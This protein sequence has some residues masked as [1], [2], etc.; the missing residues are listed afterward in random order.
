MLRSGA[1]VV[2]AGRRAE[3]IQAA[4]EQLK[5]HGDEVSG[6]PIDAG[7]PDDLRKLLSEMREIPDILVNAAGGN[8]PGATALPGEKNFFELKTEELRDV[9]DLNLFSGALLPCQ[10]IGEEMAR[11]GRPASIINITSVAAFLPLTRVV[12]YS[13][14][15]AAVENF[16]RWLAVHL[17]RDLHSQIRVNTLVPGFYLTEQNRYLL[18]REDGSLS[19]RGETIKAQT[20]LGRFGRPE[21]LAGAAIY[22]ASPASRY[23]TGS[24][25]AV[26][27][28]FTA[29]SGV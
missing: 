19:E 29:F 11:S 6:F 13:A 5:P 22:L 8:R 4:L 16:T 20:P 15:K 1:R 28:G 21:E 14:A 9:V 17:A 3:R 23:V 7:N 25:L 24:V 10:I 12:A 2:I 26:D 18:T 27:G